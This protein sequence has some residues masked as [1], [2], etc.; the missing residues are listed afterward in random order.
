MCLVGGYI[1]VGIYM[2][3]GGGAH[4]GYSYCYIP[5]YIYVA[6]YYFQTRLPEKKTVRPIAPY[7]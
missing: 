1:I 3:I 4:R 6:L 2:V 5:T 7:E